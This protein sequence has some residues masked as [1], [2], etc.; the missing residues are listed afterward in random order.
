[1][2]GKMLIRVNQLRKRY[3]QNY[4]SL[5]NERKYSECK[6]SVINI[7]YINKDNKLKQYIIYKTQEDYILQK[8][9]MESLDNQ[10][11]ENLTI[12]Q[13]EYEL[14]IFLR[15]Y[16]TNNREI[17]KK[18]FRDWK[19]KLIT[20]VQK[21]IIFYY[22]IENFQL[23]QINLDLSKDVTLC[24]SNSLIKK[25]NITDNIPFTD[26]YIDHNDVY[27]Y[28][29]TTQ[30]VLAVQVLGVHNYIAIKKANEKARLAVDLINFLNMKNNAKCVLLN[31]VYQQS[32]ANNTYYHNF[33]LYSVN[34][35][36][37]RHDIGLANCPVCRLDANYSEYN[38]VFSPQ[39]IE[40]VLTNGI[41][42]LGESR[43][44]EDIRMKFIKCMVAL[45]S[46]AEIDPKGSS[47]SLVEQVSTFTS[48]L[49]EK[50]PVKRLKIKSKVKEEY[51][52]RSRIIHGGDCEVTWQDC[53]FI[54]EI[55]EKIINKII[56]LPRFKGY[57]SIKEIWQDMQS[58]MMKIDY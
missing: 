31:N 48:V 9:I 4:I 8:K 1:M 38:F 25:W 15:P 57:R 43:L 10:V 46:V 21:G 33:Y 19:K 36:S 2:A 27:K 35:E 13:L 34:D 18:E 24:E 37:P 42:W 29:S 30:T 26:G 44:E 54:Y 52:K 28:L 53:N 20:I 56:E 49:L 47:V 12:R 55:S 22:P 5:N 45:E 7:P 58:E 40:V 23:D 11:K 39:N 14:D 50:N 6:Y 17:K 3:I 51:N 16:I 32:P 41:R